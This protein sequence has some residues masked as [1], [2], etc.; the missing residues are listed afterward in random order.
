[1]STRAHVAQQVHADDV[2][3]SISD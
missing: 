1:M 3:T 2:V